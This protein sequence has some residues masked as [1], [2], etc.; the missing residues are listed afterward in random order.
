MRKFLLAAALA[1][2][3]TSC[4]WYENHKDDVQLVIDYAVQ[5]CNFKPKVE[6]V[7]AM[8]SAPNPTVVGAF[9]IAMAICTAITPSQ[10][11]GLMSVPPTDSDD[12]PKVNGV[13]IE[14]DFVPP[15]GEK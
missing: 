13:C 10:S 15:E 12:C 1:L 6:S 7:L 11:Q 2:P 5:L 4:G 8:V 14:G 9:Q 3:L